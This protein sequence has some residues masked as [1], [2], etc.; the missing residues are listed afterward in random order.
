METMSAARGKDVAMPT[1]LGQ[2]LPIVTQASLSCNQPDW[3]KR[4]L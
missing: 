2:A 3:F 4:D 1:K